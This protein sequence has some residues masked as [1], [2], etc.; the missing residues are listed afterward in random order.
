MGGW[1]CDILS[2]FNAV[3]DVVTGCWVRLLNYTDL[4]NNAVVDRSVIGPHIIFGVNCAIEVFRSEVRD[5]QKFNK[6]HVEYLN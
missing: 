1:R 4:I 5:G 2:I 3:V 6:R